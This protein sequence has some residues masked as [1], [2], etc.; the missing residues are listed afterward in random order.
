MT[1]HNLIPLYLD[2]SSFCIYEEMQE[3]D[4]QNAS[5]IEE[6]L[7]NAFSLNKFAAHR[8][9]MTRKWL[10]EEP[11]DIYMY[12]VD[13]HKLSKLVG[14]S[15]KEIINCAFIVGFPSGVSA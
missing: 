12:L 7:V 10:P 1:F 9:L 14:I 2:G 8:K 13:L 6:V 11:V 5:R 3:K 15:D 4:K